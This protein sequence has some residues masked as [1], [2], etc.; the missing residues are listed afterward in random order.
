M[1][2]APEASILMRGLPLEITRSLEQ[3]NLHLFV[4]A[5]NNGYN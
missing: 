2:M 4:D 5:F 3:K 1:R